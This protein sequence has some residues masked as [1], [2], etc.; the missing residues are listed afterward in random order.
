M[1]FESGPETKEN[2]KGRAVGKGNLRSSSLSLPDV[3]G[4]HK[5]RVKMFH[6]AA[7]RNT[8]NAEDER[9]G[10]EGND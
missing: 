3:G 2:R 4:L 5:S 6:S 1:V 7:V 9:L 10:R 8:T